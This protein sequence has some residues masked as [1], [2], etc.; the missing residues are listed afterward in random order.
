MA[1]KPCRECG[2][3][4][5]AEAEQCP[6]CGVKIQSGIGCLGWTLAIFVFLIVLAAVGQ[7]NRSSPSVSPSSEDLAKTLF[8]QTKK[9]L[10]LEKKTWHKTAF[11][12]F[13]LIL[14]PT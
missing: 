7:F 4:I 13:I 11:D 6:H 1:L 8:N 9:G 5:S 2:K 3:E 14:F 12:N 10:S